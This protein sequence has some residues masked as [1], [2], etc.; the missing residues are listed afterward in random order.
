MKFLIA[1]SDLESLLKSVGMTR[2]KKRDTLVL[3]A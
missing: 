3:S 2:P 1:F